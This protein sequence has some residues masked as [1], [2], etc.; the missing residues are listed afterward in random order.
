V[1]RER[2]RRASDLAP[3][4]AVP[5]PPDL[6][7]SLA[8]AR[9]S[10]PDHAL[11]EDEAARLLAHFGVGVLP[12]AL[13]DSADEAVGAAERLGYPVV[14]KLHARTIVHKTEAGGVRLDLRRADEVRAAY[15]SVAGKASA[16]GAAHAQVRLTPYR[17]G[18]V[19]ALV[20]ARRDPELGPLLVAGVGGVRAEAEAQV[21]IRVL[22]CAPEETTAMLAEGGLAR[23][24]AHT[25][26]RAAPDLRSVAASLGAVARLILSVPEVTEVEVNPLRCAHDGCVALDA[27]VLVAAP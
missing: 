2:A 24:L 22:P 4:S 19:E 20:G 18:G 17:R 13:A 15:V 6:G 9:A 5:L 14:L 27:R 16:G 11:T 25:R 3:G 7:S 12:A 23:L 1:A 21:A 26:G 10:P 8:R